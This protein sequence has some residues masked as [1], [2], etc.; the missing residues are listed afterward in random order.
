LTFKELRQAASNEIYKNLKLD[1]IIQK[2]NTEV[3]AY[4]DFPPDGRKKL[5]RISKVT[6]EGVELYNDEVER[7]RGHA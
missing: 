2:E 6:E 5:Y 3:R 1:D 7:P 4:F